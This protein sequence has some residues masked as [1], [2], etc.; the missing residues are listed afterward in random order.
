MYTYMWYGYSYV[1]DYINKP[2]LL[3]LPSV[4]L[5]LDTQVIAIT[6]YWN[7]TE[8][9]GPWK[10]IDYHLHTYIQGIAWEHID[11]F[12]NAIICELIEHVSAISFLST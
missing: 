5:F 11:Y 6:I 12:N 7:Y 2:T 4:Y 3:A 1:Y 10:R 8:C 9:I